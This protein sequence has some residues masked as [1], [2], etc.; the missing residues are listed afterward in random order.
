[1]NAVVAEAERWLGTPFH[2][3]AAVRG[4]GCDC[5]GLV[6]GVGEAVTG[7]RVGMPSWA[8]D[9]SICSI[10]PWQDDFLAHLAQLAGKIHAGEGRAGDVALFGMDKT[11][12]HCGI[13]ASEHLFIHAVEDGGVQLARM[14]DRW[15]RRLVGVWRYHG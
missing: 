12:V 4:A 1:M 9:L 13:V 3:G 15:Q 11:I 7:R 2:L 10:Q 5:F 14:A 6:V 8:Y